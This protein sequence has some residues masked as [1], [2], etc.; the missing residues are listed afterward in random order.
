MTI[1]ID[2]TFVVQ[3]KLRMPLREFYKKKKATTYEEAVEALHQA[4]VSVGTRD[5]V[6]AQLPVSIKKVSTAIDPDPAPNSSRVVR[7]EKQPRKKKKAKSAPT[8]R[9]EEPK[10]E[11]EVAA[12]AITKSAPVKEP[13]AK[14]PKKRRTKKSLTKTSTKKENKI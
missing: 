12:D 5:E 13:K 14:A 9:N 2:W 4:G 1:N 6:V 10:S 8:N 7:P 3:S 11:G